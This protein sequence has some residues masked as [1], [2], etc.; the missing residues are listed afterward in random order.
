MDKE[1]KALSNLCVG[2]CDECEEKVSC[3]DSPYFVDVMA[4]L[5][6]EDSL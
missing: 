3:P 5:D 4:C 6:E 1:E 2:D